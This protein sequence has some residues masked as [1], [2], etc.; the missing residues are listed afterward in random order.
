MTRG[1]KWIQIPVCA[2]R[3]QNSSGRP[4]PD[5]IMLFQSG[6]YAFP[7]TCQIQGSRSS[8]LPPPPLP[9]SRPAI[10]R[11]NMEGRGGGVVGGWSRV[12]APARD[13]MTSIFKHRDFD[14]FRRTYVLHNYRYVLYVGLTGPVY[15]SLSRTYRFYGS[16]GVVFSKA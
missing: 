1:S 2:M 11:G 7:R 4:K 10:G 12:R 8:L 3:A 5:S 15:C 6:S 14:A 16:H 13:M 9:R